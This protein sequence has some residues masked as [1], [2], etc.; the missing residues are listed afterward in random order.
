MKRGSNLWGEISRLDAKILGID[1]KY[2]WFG[3]SWR[4]ARPLR[5]HEV[6]TRATT[7]HSPSAADGSGSLLPAPA[8]AVHIVYGSAAPAVAALACPHRAPA[9]GWGVPKSLPTLTPRSSRPGLF[10]GRHALISGDISA[11]R[12]PMFRKFKIGQ[13][14]GYRP[15]RGT[16]APEGAFRVTALLPARNDEFEYRI[17]HPDE[18]HDRVVCESDLRVQVS[19]S[20]Y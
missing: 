5:F 12:K 19:R 2:A 18:A 6:G 9:A 15:R 8:G 17:R 11:T 20:L 4:S 1:P 10:F 16:Y 7:A 3:I 14:V 13:W